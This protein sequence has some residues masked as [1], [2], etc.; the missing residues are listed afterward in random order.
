MIVFISGLLAVAWLPSLHYTPLLVA[1]ALPFMLRRR[2]RQ[3]I[4]LFSLGVAYAA[5]WGGWQLSHRLPDRFA[6]ADV[7]LVGVIDELPRLQGRR[8]SFTLR[9]ISI[10]SEE[11]GL[12]RLRRLS[13]SHYDAKEVLKAGDRIAARVR[14][15]PPRGL[16]NPHAFDSERR[17]LVESID[18]RGYVR[19]L[20]SKARSGFTLPGVR[21]QLADRLDHHFEP[22]V[23]VTLR[24]L[25]LG[26]RSGLDPDGWKLL[27]ETGTAH[28][29][30]VSGVHIA[31]MAGLGLM[32]ARCLGLLLL[33]GGGDSRTVRMAGLLF[34]LLL[35]CTYALIA[36]MG[37]PVQR[38][39]IMVAVFIGAE[40]WLRPV[41]A[42][43]RWRTALLGV[44]LLQPLAVIEPGA[45][46]SFGAV[47]LLIWISQLGIGSGGRLG[48]WWSVQGRLF[49]GMMPLSALLFQQL[50]FLAPVVNFVALPAVSLLIM[51]LPLLL[52]LVF[53]GALWPADLLSWAVE[54][55]WQGIALSRAELGLYLALPRTEPFVLLLAVAAV[56]WWLF[57]LPL[58]WRWL[59]IC[60]LFPLLSIEVERPPEGGFE[61]RMFDVGQGLAVLIET[62]EGAIIYD[63]GPGYPGGGS[64]FNYAV[65]PLLKARGLSG[66]E[67][68]VISHGD[69][70]HSG[71]F[72][73]LQKG[74]R[75]RE[76]VLGQP[77]DGVK[78]WTDCARQPGI[79][80]GG[81]RFRYLQASAGV[82]G[83][84]NAYSC[85]L[86]V[87]SR[88]CVLVIPGDLE[89][90][91]ERDLVR[92]YRLPGADWL[93][94]G[95]HGSRTSTSTEWLD[96]LQPKEVLFS[97]GLFNRFGHPAADVVERV[98]EAG[99]VIHDTAREGA[100]RL[101]AGEEC[102]TSAWRQR[103]KRY[104]TA[105]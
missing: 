5:I 53:L 32:L 104:W 7:D 67:Q 38:A 24:A 59:S 79:E 14:L 3:S 42:W 54:T 94:A 13:L 82:L 60:M 73:A 66:L 31:V 83:N 65:A 28:L 74:Y 84:D 81:V 64:A 30:V 40:W 55:F 34:A 78:N 96:A 63:T 100:L 20:E 77:L 33:W 102:R 72:A 61:A 43:Q 22:R 92:R 88:R 70:D 44:S 85:V 103:K 86:V 16:S 91:G 2:L 69:S 19:S 101:E 98:R 58:K 12:L 8:Q 41:T 50:G 56:L 99:A 46:L 97:R 90:E 25:V 37:L 49:I 23:S 29:L 6:R 95:H 11:A 93:V 105:G 68:V 26:D 76:L 9:I 47:A 15:F 21:Q 39:L 10:D 1:F 4:L 89:I 35:A 71:G 36:G 75:Y 80:L 48:Q 27:S 62:A 52:P 57:P 51:T 45:W 17:F 18:A 87:E